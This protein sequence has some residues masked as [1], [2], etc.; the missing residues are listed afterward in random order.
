MT[1]EAIDAVAT[2]TLIF[3]EEYVKITKGMFGVWT[4]HARQAARTRQIAILLNHEHWVQGQPLSPR[5]MG[6]SSVGVFNCWT[7]TNTMPDE[8]YWIRGIRVAAGC[9]SQACCM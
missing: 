7:S 4:S 3:S 9:S 5:S 1:T 8:E 6:S 2:K